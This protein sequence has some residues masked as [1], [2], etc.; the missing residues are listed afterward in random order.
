M[1]KKMSTNQWIAV[2]LSILVVGFIF[3]ISTRNSA[4]ITPDGVSRAVSEQFSKMNSPEKRMM[5]RDMIQ[6]RGA[7][8]PSGLLFEDLIVGEGRMAEQGKAVSV[9]YDGYLTDETLF[10]SSYER[11]T[12]FQ[13]TLGAGEVIRGWDEG[14][15]G[16]Q[17]GGLRLLVIPPSM[18]YGEVGFGPIPPN[19]TLIF[20]VELLA[21]ED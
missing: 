8:D 2:V 4:R 9:H 6:T 10:D 20:T 11:G 7:E 15:L 13:F 12:P 14:V 16:M 18:A 3:F 5:A 17:E 1:N 19:S 21:V